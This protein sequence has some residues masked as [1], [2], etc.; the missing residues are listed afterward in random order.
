MGEWIYKFRTPLL[1]TGIFLSYLLHASNGVW[2][3][4]FW[5]H[6][7]VVSELIRHPWH[8]QHP[9]LGND[10]PHVF[11]TPYSLLVAMVAKLFHLNSVE[12]L[13]FFGLLN[14]AILFYGLNQYIASLVTPFKRA[15]FFYSVLLILFFW[16]ADP[17][18]YSGFFHSNI[19]NFSLPY[20]SAFATGLVFFAFAV[21][22]KF[23]E[24]R[25]F[26]YVLMLSVMSAVIIL[27]HAVAFIFLCAG[28]VSETFGTK[29]EQRWHLVAL[30]VVLLFA[31]ICAL[32]WPYYPF[33]EMLRGASDVYHPSNKGIYENV[34]KTIWPLFLA[35]PFIAKD[36]YK[37]QN[38]QLSGT[39]V[40]LIM[41]YVVAWVSQKYSYGRVISYIAMLIQIM[42]GMKLARWDDQIFKNKCVTK[43]I[44]ILLVIIF[45]G[46]S[47]GQLRSVFTRAMTAI[48][49]LYLGRSVL[50][51]QTF[52][53]Y[54]FLQKEITQGD[55]VL[56][57][58]KTS[59]IIPSFG[60]K[61][62]T[63]SLPHAFVTNHEER[64]ADVSQFFKEEMSNEKS[65]QI[66]KKYQPKYIFFNKAEDKNWL[67][68]TQELIA[69]KV[70]QLVYDSESV[71]LYKLDLTKLNG[72]K[73]TQQ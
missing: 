8:P 53:Q 34:V 46:T 41:V 27:T 48:N 23:K 3:D 67:D 22:A 39:L 40:L 58:V 1:L 32:L 21:N 42:V 55:V 71:A 59:W 10:L 73:A 68:I 64:I 35:L 66:I 70:G 12:I 45:I 60:A 31:L 24:T 72:I 33:L 44:P 52:A 4:D 19:L 63:L 15:T 69:L 30:S 49:S 6:S 62:L 14:A 25:E 5:D 37:K 56:A 29:S 18:N 28:L 47:Y 36:L 2:V 57:N 11:F 13:S 61:V 51:Q 17:W 38:Q 65:L 16:G 54:S 50:N 43:I 26:K 9:Q 7:A 20:P